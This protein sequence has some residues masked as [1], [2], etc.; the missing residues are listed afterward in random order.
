MQTS[1]IS[2]IL[3]LALKAISSSFKC[4]FRTF[5][6]PSLLVTTMSAMEKFAISVPANQRHI[7][8]KCVPVN[9]QSL[10]QCRLKAAVYNFCSSSS[11]R[12]MGL[13]STSTPIFK[14]VHLC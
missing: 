3:L 4:S 13:C 6:E 7:L 8:P 9:K 14:R 1:E 5:C 2:G 10:L 11:V 12:I